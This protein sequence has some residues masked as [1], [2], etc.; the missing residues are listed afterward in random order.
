MDNQSNV[1]V[2]LAVLEA[3]EVRRTSDEKDLHEAIKGLKKEVHELRSWKLRL[4]YPFAIIGVLFVGACTAIGAYIV[5]S[6]T[7]E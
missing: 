1:E 2:R 7:G 4:Q 6:F 5:K 3:K